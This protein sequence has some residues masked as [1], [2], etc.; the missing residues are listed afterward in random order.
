MSL[1]KYTIIALFHIFWMNITIGKTAMD[2]SFQ[3]NPPNANNIFKFNRTIKFP[4]SPKENSLEIDNKEISDEN[5][6]L[7]RKYFC[8][9]S[10]LKTF[11][12]SFF[13]MPCFARQKIFHLSINRF[14]GVKDIA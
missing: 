14:S 9:A 2:T 13:F 4:N 10:Y 1:P 6:K 8:F 3:H 12:S 5:I 11:F 7:I